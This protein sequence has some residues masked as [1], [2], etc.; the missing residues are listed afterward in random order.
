MKKIKN[1]LIFLLVTLIGFGAVACDNNPDDVG[2]VQAPPAIV[3][4]QSGS[5]SVPE[6]TN[7]Y[8]VENGLS[9]YKIVIPEQSSTIV[10]FAANELESF[11]AEATGIHLPIITD[12]GL[13]YSEDAKYF[14]IGDTALFEQV[15]IVKEQNL[16]HSGVQIETVG[17]TIFMLGG[18]TDNG[19]LYGVY[20]FLAEALNF[21]Y[22]GNECYTLNRNVKNIK[23]LDFDNYVN[24]PSVQRR[25]AGSGINTTNIVEMYRFRQ[26]HFYTSFFAQ[27]NTVP[28]HNSLEYVKG[29]DEGHEAYWYSAEGNQ[30]CYTAHGIEEEYEAM[31][32]ACLE[33]LIKMVV[34]YPDKNDASLTISDSSAFCGCDACSVNFKKYGCQSGS[35]VLFCND[36]RA[37]LEDWF[38][39][40]EGAPHKREYTLSFFAYMSTTAAPVK[41]NSSTN[42]WEGIDGIKCNDG[43]GVFYAPID[44]DFTRSIYSPENKEF[45]DAFYGW[46]AITDKLYV[47]SYDWDFRSY[48]TPYDTFD[49]LSDLYKCM[50]SFNVDYIFQ[51]SDHYQA[52]GGSCWEMLK[53]YLNSKLAWDCNADVNQL[54]NDFFTNFYGPVATDM[55]ALFDSFRVHSAYLKANNANYGGRQSCQ[56]SLYDARW[57]PKQMLIDWN[58]RYDQIF[59]KIKPLKETDPKLYEEIYKRVALEQ[60]SPIY[61]LLY[62]YSDSVDGAMAKDL[63][64]KFKES[65]ELWGISKGNYGDPISDTYKSIGIK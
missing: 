3:P 48:Y 43:V 60:Q 58:N 19:A 10:G 39:T 1:I 55:R 30:L 22:F 62:L 44:A 38:N 9:E 57:Y 51:E 20:E 17:K 46:R 21:E 40:E 65:N 27:I 13:T 56:V 24:I 54:I 6:D 42:K 18:D 32:N 64:A 63:R 52:E 5:S 4:E 59:D 29:K 7:N 15:Q 2:G 26:E 36:L 47:W 53:M 31:Q 37:K 12:S 16:G 33:S 49:T 34:D 50:E 23:L 8:I 14:S 41:Y 28:W 35:I 61:L 25:M 11:F 45:L